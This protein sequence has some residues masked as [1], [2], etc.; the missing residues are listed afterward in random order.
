[1]NKQEQ[2]S[3][4]VSFDKL[5]KIFKETTDKH[6]P[7]NKERIGDSQASFMTKELSKQIMKR[8]KSKNLYFKWPSRENFF[9]HEN[10]KKKQKQTNKKTPKK[11]MQQH[12][13]IC[14]K[15]FLFH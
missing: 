15:F 13:Q 1:M 14:W 4:C 6:A 8:S 12:D 3:M 10:E 5:T 11:Q 2:A 7:Q 9:A